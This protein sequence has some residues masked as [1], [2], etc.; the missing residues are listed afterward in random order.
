MIERSNKEIRR[1]TNAI[2]TFVS[3]HSIKNYTGAVL[4]NINERWSKRKYLDMADFYLNLKE[5]T[6]IEYKKTLEKCNSLKIAK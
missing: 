2:G 4:I 5:K 1:R 6:K 3:T